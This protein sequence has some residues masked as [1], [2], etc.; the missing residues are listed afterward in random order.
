MA[1]SLKR[2]FIYVLADGYERPFSFNHPKN[3]KTLEEVYLAK[4]EKKKNAFHLSLH[5][6]EK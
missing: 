6:L 5:L 2:K 1:C 4:K 3:R